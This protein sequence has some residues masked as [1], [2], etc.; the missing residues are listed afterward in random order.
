GS[1]GR[2]RTAM[3][4]NT[5]YRAHHSTRIT[6]CQM[7][8]GDAPKSGWARP[9]AGLRRLCLPTGVEDRVI[10]GV[11]R[12]LHAGCGEPHAAVVIAVGFGG[13]P[14]DVVVGE[15]AAMAVARGRTRIDDEVRRAR[16]QTT[17]GARGDTARR[18]LPFAGRGTPIGQQLVVVARHSGPVG[19]A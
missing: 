7:R 4:L 18:A 13:V 9:N 5:L 8:T 16:H 6:L 2:S 11:D 12:M 1:R 10:Q 15:I 14:G 17:G 19:A 3:N